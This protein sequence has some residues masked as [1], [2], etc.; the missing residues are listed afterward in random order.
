MVG[1]KGGCVLALGG[2]AIAV[3]TVG[4]GVWLL[5]GAA[6]LEHYEDIPGCLVLAIGG[7]IVGFIVLI[8]GIVKFMKENSSPDG[9]EKKPP[10]KRC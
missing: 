7:P 5:L 8:V 9:L 10:E 3:I 2:C 4:L 1:N 6:T